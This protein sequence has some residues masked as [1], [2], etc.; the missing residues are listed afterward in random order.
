MLI[1]QLTDVF[2]IG[3]GNYIQIEEVPGELKAYFSRLCQL[4]LRSNADNT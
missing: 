1:L 3:V 2:D 4:V